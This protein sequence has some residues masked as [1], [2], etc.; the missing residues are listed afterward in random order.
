ML[1]ADML[2]VNALLLK[3]QKSSE[4]TN[5]ANSEPQAE[6]AHHDAIN[7][8]FSS[9]ST[10]ID[11]LHR[12]ANMIRRASTSRQ[13]A[14]ASKFHLTDSEGGDATPIYEQIFRRFIMRDFP[15]IQHDFCDRLISTMLLRRRRILYRRSR[16]VKL[17]LH[18]PKPAPKPTQLT[19]SMPFAHSVL[20][21]PETVRANSAT[22]SDIASHATTVPSATWPATNPR[23]V[24]APSRISEARTV[25]MTTGLKD[26]I[27]MPPRIALTETEF[28]CPF[29]SLI[30]PAAD[31]RNRTK[32]AD[33][34][35]K[36]LD[37]YVC[38]F[39]PCSQGEDIFGS[40]ADWIAHEQVHCMR[41]YC[42][43]KAHKTEVFASEEDFVVHMN[44]SHPR[45]FKES[46]LPLLAKNS[47]RPTKRIFDACPF[48]GE[49]AT[50]LGKT[51]EDHVAHHLQYL[52]LLSLPHCDD[53]YDAD[54]AKS[55]SSTESPIA[56]KAAASRTTTRSLRQAMLPV[57]FSDGYD[58][59]LVVDKSIPDIE[60]QNLDEVV[61]KRQFIRTGK[62]ELPYMNQPI[63]AVEQ[64]R[65][66]T[67]A[68][69]IL[70]FKAEQERYE[71][72]LDS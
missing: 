4:H 27:P 69:F 52:A 11:W 38:V 63:T 44:T 22:P 47:R 72:T 55:T 68:G 54:T 61:Q 17:A 25:V 36:D 6:P 31:A 62:I 67:L 1:L 13:N 30:L 5:D 33:H 14:R 64:L 53:K 21:V 51:L 40:S 43:V 7:E 9:L 46:Q 56:G 37:S 2:P 50:E 18:N 12:I 71:E 32:W 28:I 19:L 57:D 20:D 35:K 66:K 58:P 10:S 15:N 42:L 41:W 49:E 16:Q 29:C 70:R 8:I 65:D 23:T 24:P 3:L 59:V 34:V 39:F 60:E 48:C 45:K 26:M